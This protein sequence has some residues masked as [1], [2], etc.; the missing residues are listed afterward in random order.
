MNSQ[1]LGDITGLLANA[2]INVLAI[3][4][5]TDMTEHTATMRL[6]VEISNL[7]ALGQLLARIN[8]LANVISASR[9]TESGIR[10][11]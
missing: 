7:V 11:G 5:Q 1:L 9:Q 6:T 10:V 2:K 8:S 4:T 3:N